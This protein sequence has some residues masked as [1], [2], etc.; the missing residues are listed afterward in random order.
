MTRRIARWALVALVAAWLAP[1]SAFAHATIVSTTP[2]DT[3]VVKTAPRVA[4]M[5]WS[6]SVDLGD[7]AV[8]LLDAR[9]KEIETV[10]ARHKPGDAT[11]AVLTLPPD[12]KNGTY[13]IS[14]RVVSSDSHPVTGAFSFSIGSPSA[15]L[16]AA[17]GSSSATVRFIDAV[18]RGVAFLG[19]AVAVGGG[20][21]LLVLWPEGAANARGQRVV[22]IG[23]GALLAGSVA[24]LLLQGPYASGGS[25]SK[26]FSPSLVSFSL[27]TRFGHALI[28]RIV[29]AAALAVVFGLLLRRREPW[30]L[31]AAGACVVG[32]IL[33]WTLTDHSR[34][35]VQTWLGI[36]AGSL[37]L[38]AM[39]LWFGGLVLLLACVLGRSDVSL[40]PVVPRFSRFAL[41]CFAVLG[42]SGLYLAWRQVGT[43][44]A[45][46]KTDF[47]KLLLLK[48][49]IV[50]VIVGLAY[51]SR[52]AVAR[53]GGGLRT[54]VA[55][56]AFLG[57]AALG[58]TAT[59]VN[60]AP[61]R[62]SYIDP[63]H[64]TVAGPAGTRV[65]VSVNPAKQGPNVV[66]VYLVKRDGM[67]LVVPEL[68]AKLI[69]PDSSGPT[70]VPLGS[71]EPGHYV[72]SRMSAPYPGKWK[73]RLQ[74]RTSDIDERDVDI[75]VRIR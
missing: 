50:A 62:V 61:A 71:A 54:S 2:E 10:P 58:V 46:P 57:V 19:L 18:S 31:W 74:I 52:R 43:F 26:L 65:Q 30:L 68:T 9:G 5:K 75:P 40:E 21:L 38:L 59:L 66:D 28:V 41:P 11:T 32:L 72:A 44:P 7:N 36:P 45:L 8:K 42:V 17:D 37:H 24:V 60:T 6:E 64:A 67:L 22:W 49:G 70:N 23:I 48:S 56:E 25:L 27:S 20:F 63:V 1:A 13:V 12:L 16:F 33:T 53:G 73:L 34:T 47:G 15:V 29:L 39:A 4:T 55:G 51:L 69:P 35:G 3:S 14:W